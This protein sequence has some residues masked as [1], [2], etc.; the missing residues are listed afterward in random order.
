[1]TDL[2]EASAVIGIAAHQGRH[3]ERHTEPSAT[4]R[5][6]HLV[7]LVG[8]LGVAEAGELSNSPGTAAVATWIQTTVE[9]ELPRPADPL[10]TLV[11]V[12]IL[13]PVDRIEFEA[14]D[15]GEVD[16]TNLAFRL[17]LGKGSRPTLSATSSVCGHRNLQWSTSRTWPFALAWAK[18][19][20]QRS[21]P[22]APCAVIA[23]SNGRRP[24]KQG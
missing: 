18:A 13:R 21:L 12:L 3:V 7:T 2:A 24:S 11:G 4:G 5:Q 23:T 15:G 6:D 9:G 17:S 20:A 10:H 22:P 16:V 19:A 14:R 8:L 1:M